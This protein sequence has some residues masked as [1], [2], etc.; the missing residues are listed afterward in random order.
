MGNIQIN[1]EVINGEGKI[2]KVTHIYPQGKK[3]VYRVTFSDRT[4]VLCA[5]NH[6][7]QVYQYGKGTRKNN[8]LSTTQLIEGLK[9]GKK[10][11]IPVPIIDCWKNTLDFNPYLM[12]VL[13][14]DGNLTNLDSVKVSLFEKDIQVT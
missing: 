9:Q 6:L 12:G 1:D 2:T 5:D 13:L 14:G 3:P 8:V 4:S 10:Y 7:W 11:R